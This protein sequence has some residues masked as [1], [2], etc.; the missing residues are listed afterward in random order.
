V[1]ADRV[2]GQACALA[3]PSA[4]G[5]ARVGVDG[6]V[7][8]DAALVADAVAAAVAERG[9]PVAR[10]SAEDFLRPRSVRVEFGADDPDAGYERWYD[11]AALR[12]E[13][14]DPF[15]LDGAWLPSLWDVERDRAT[16]AAQQHAAPGTVAVVDGAFLLRWETA[17]AFDVTVH[18]VVSDGAIARRLPAA[19]VARVSGAWRRYVAET[20]PA[21]RADV[22]LRCDDPTKPALVL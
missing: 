19:D 2:A 17:D 11:W 5:R 22:V 7:P 9:R 14:L 13:V 1:L 18:L 16:R 8:A 21:S 10:V 15:V 3:D 4:G 20:D 6:P 12:R